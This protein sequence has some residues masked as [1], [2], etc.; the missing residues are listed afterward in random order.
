MTMLLNFYHRY[1]FQ[2]LLLLFYTLCH[3]G[4]FFIY[5]AVY[6]DDWTLFNSDKNLILST[7]EQSGGAFFNF[8]GNLH[9]TVIPIGGWIYKLLT[10]ILYYFSALLFFNILLKNKYITIESSKLIVLLFLILPLNSA[11]VALIDFPYTLGYFLFFLAWNFKHIRVVSLPL[12]FFSFLVNSLPFLYL[13]VAINLY[14]ELY[15]SISIKNVRKFIFRK[16]DYLLLPILFF[17][18]KYKFFTTSGL[19][20]TYNSNFQ[21]K[22]LVITPIHQLIDFAKLDVNLF[23]LF[24]LLFVFNIIKPF[25]R[26]VIKSNFKNLYFG[27]L[28]LILAVFPY[29][30]LG[31]TPSFIEWSSR[32]QLLMPLG[33]ALIIA[34]FISKVTSSRYLLFSL[35]LSVSILINSSNY[36]MFY[37]DWNKQK[38]LISQLQKHSLLKERKLILVKDNTLE[39]NALDRVYRF[40]EWNG[41]LKYAYKNEYRFVMN[42]SDRHFYEK[43]VFDDYFNA[44]GNANGHVKQDLKSA[45]IITIDKEESNTTLGQIKNSIYPKLL[46]SISQ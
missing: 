13:L 24:L 15:S 23:L 19:Y 21:I 26:I 14:F 43:G 6:W 35:I 11:R 18:V 33:V 4:I 34:F 3:G 30:I 8:T 20:K 29:W 22:N 36:L 25:E 39:Y 12:F 37:I 7:F 44:F 9:S 10:Y 40:Y 32:H 2:I 17:I 46:I 31:L 28:A 42:Y 1:S 41:I 38:E 27:I 5:D 45:T 16:F